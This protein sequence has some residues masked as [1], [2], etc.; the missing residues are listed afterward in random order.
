MENKFLE[1]W[2]IPT[3]DAFLG[4]N[5]ISELKFWRNHIANLSAVELQALQKQKLQ[6][7]LQY[8][9]TTI[10]FYKNLGITLT[11]NPYQNIKH[12]P[13]LYK[14]VVKNHFEDLFI[15]D[16][17]KLVSEKS[18]GSSGIQGEVLMSKKE[19]TQY[20]AAQTFLWEWSGFRLGMPFLQTGITP[21]RGFL[22]AT[23]DKLFN[24]QYVNAYNI[25]YGNAVTNLQ[26]AQKRKTLFFG[27]YA[28]SLNVY[29]EIAIKA[30]IQVPL[31]GVISWGDKLFDHYKANIS[32]AFGTTNIA[33]QYGTTEGFVI[34]GTC[35]HGKLHQLSPQTYL[36]L[37]DKN[38]NEVAPGELGYVV[39]TRLDAYSFPLIR[40]YLGDLA[41]KEETSITCPCGKKMPILKKIIG[42]DTDVI[43]TPS[44]KYLVVHFFTGVFEHFPQIKQFRVIQKIVGQIFIEYIAGEGFTLEVLNQL[45]SKMYERAQENFPI[46]WQAV[47]EIP[48][49]ASGKP[50]LVQS[51]VATRKIGN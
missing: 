43:Q 31:Q 25:S 13:I 9:T 47:S 24:T 5:F 42:R 38:G 19:N 49:T 50:Q 48:P 37:L 27:G 18:S 12:F 21:D 22:K 32:Q 2:I 46:E 26:I 4:T 30:G 8:A 14:Q 23:K 16:R 36:E 7:L 33:E 10:P 40:Y 29:A 17:A 15:E 44:G 3:A 51:L 39:V 11:D 20:Q 41:I 45:S 28:S 1:K 35:N 6:S 34:A